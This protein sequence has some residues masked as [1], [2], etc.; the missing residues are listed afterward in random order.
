MKKLRQ[1]T[2]ELIIERKKIMKILRGARAR[3]GN[4]SSAL[5]C[6][7]TGHDVSHMPIFKKMTVDEMR[8]KILELETVISENEKIL[9]GLYYEYK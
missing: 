4:M 8:N 3:S 5:K 7:D 1:D 6:L 9:D 2:P